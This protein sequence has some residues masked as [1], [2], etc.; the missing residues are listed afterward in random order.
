MAINGEGNNAPDQ[1]DRGEI[2]TVG[3]EGTPQAKQ[4]ISWWQDRI[5]TTRKMR[6]PDFKIMHEDSRMARGLQWD[7]QKDLND[8]RYVV[9]IVQSEI[10]ASV[11][12]LYAKNPTF[13]AKRKP[14]MDFAIWDENPKTYEDAIAQVQ[15]ALQVAAQTPP[16]I[17]YDQMGLPVQIPAQPQI[18]PDAQ[19]LI[20]DVNRGQIARE[21]ME[22]TARTLEFLMNQQIQQQQPPFKQEMKQ[23]IRRVE[24]N[25]AGYVKIGYQRVEKVSPETQM[26]LNDL[27]TRLATLEATY[28]TLEDG[29]ADNI[30]RER[31]SLRIQI[32]TLQETPAVITREGLTVNFPR[33]TAL[34]IDG[35][36]TQLKGFVGARWIAEEYHLTAGTIKKIYKKDVKNKGCAYQRSMLTEETPWL[37]KKRENNSLS[38]WDDTY[39]VWEVYN[40]DDGSVFT[41]CE[42]YDEYLLEPTAPDVLLEQFYPYYVLS[43]NDIEDSTSIYGVSTARLIKHQQ[44]EINRQKESLR[45]HRINSKPQYATVQGSMTEQDRR[46]METAPAFGVIELAA[47]AE[48]QS[49]DQLFQQI[50][51]HPIDPNMYDSNSTVSDIRLITRRSDARLGGVSKASATADS[52]AEDSRIGEDKSKGD[53][54]DDLLTAF[55]RDA[56][57]ILMMNMSKEQVVKIVGPGATWPDSDPTLLLQ[58]LYLDVE[59]GSTGKP[60][61]ALEVANFQRLFPILLQTPGITPKWVAKKAISLSDGAVDFTEAYLDGMPSIQAMNMMMQKTM[62][63]Q[64]ATGDPAT[65]PAQQGAQGG[66]K[67]ARPPGQDQS[68]TVNQG[69]NDIPAVKPGENPIAF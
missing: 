48:G 65:D 36:C 12:T 18:P 28:D 22:R 44:Q 41:I 10:A 35:N 43:F 23:L 69:M 53:E 59:A 17:G 38:D 11:A 58:D 19:A 6:E 21:S 25:Y 5:L 52:I 66:D 9:N 47:L 40:L 34:I 42:G 68:M 49:V 67:I 27:T 4:Y 29:K 15:Q 13:T 60:N 45:Q 46:N 56:G 64:P 3:Q 24:T 55:A 37:N 1:V 51:K 62:S 16:Q 30:E 54:V 33:T 20:E 26:R 57:A 7:G 14:R 8:P 39:C 61:Q 63:T 32:K 50:K 31:E 2:P